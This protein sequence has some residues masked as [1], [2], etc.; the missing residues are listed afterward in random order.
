VGPHAVVL[1]EGESDRAALAALAARRGRDLA[2][3]GVGIVPMGGV[4]NIGHFL[5]RYGPAGLG[6]RLAGLYD[7]GEEQV[8]A[9][10]L[11]RAGLG[12]DLDR[13]GMAALGFAVCV[14]DLEDE[15]IRAHGVAGTERVIAAAGELPSLRRLQRQPAQ[16]GRAPEAQLRRFLGTR[17]GRK[18]RYARLL[19]DALDLDRVPAP[20]DLVLTHV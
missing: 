1:V 17:S 15:L 4:T 20:L 10:G 16:L 8:V 11:A 13:A 5:D 6:L 18:G 3:E 14:V 9:R 2:T 19:V 12:P 7:A